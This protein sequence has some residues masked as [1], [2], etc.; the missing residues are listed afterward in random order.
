MSKIKYYNYQ[1]IGDIENNY[2]P[3]NTQLC[4]ETS[5]DVL[6]F[7]RPADLSTILKTADKGVTVSIVMSQ[8][9]NIIAMWYDRINERIYVLDKDEL[10]YLDLSDDSDNSVD[11]GLS[12][13]QGGDCFIIGTDIFVMGIYYDA[14]KGY[15]RIK[16]Y[17]SSHVWQANYDLDLGLHNIFSR[18]LSISFVVIVGTDVY[19]L[20]RWSDENCFIYK[21]DSVAN[22]YTNMEDCGANTVIPPSYNQRGITYDDSDVLSFVLQDSGD[23]KYYLHTYSITGDAITKKAEYNAT[24]MLNR[25][26]DS[27]N[28][29]PFNLEKGFDISRDA[30]DKTR[31]YQI[32]GTLLAA[33]SRVESAN[34]FAAITDTYLIDKGGALWK[35]VEFTSWMTQCKISAME[36]GAWKCEIYSKVSGKINDISSTLEIFD[37]LYFK[38]VGDLSSDSNTGLISYFGAPDNFNDEV[39]GTSGTDIDWVDYDWSV[40]A[41]AIT[42]IAEYQD[43]KNVMECKVDSGDTVDTSHVRMAETSKTYEFWMA[44]SDISKASWFYFLASGTGIGEPNT[45]AFLRFFTSKLQFGHGDGAG[46]I[47]TVDLVSPAVNNTY[48]HIKIMLDCVTDTV[49]L[50]LNGVLTIDAEEFYKDQTFDTTTTVRIHFTDAGD[51]SLYV[52]AWGETSDADYYVGKNAIKTKENVVIMEGYAKIEKIEALTKIVIDSPAMWDL[53]NKIAEGNYSGD[54][55]AIL[56][57]IAAASFQYVTAGTMSAGTAMGTIYHRGSKTGKTV[58]NTYSQFEKFTWVVKPDDGQGLLNYNDGSVDS[59]VNVSETDKISNF[60]QEVQRSVINQM[61]VKG[62]INPATGIPYTGTYNNAQSQQLYGVIPG[63]RTFAH[64]TSDAQCLAQATAMVETYENAPFKYTFTK[65]IGAE[66]LVLPSEEITFVYAPQS[67]ASAQRII[68]KITYW[69]VRGIADWEIVDALF[70]RTTQNE[71]LKE[72]VQ[73]NNDYIEQNAENISGNAKVYQAAGDPTVN[74]DV[75]LGYKRGDLW[76]NT[77]DDGAFICRNPADGAADWKEI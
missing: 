11:N 16:E 60:K 38:F 41:S 52:D 54:S 58:I 21:F 6:I 71:Q 47:T 70:Y 57:L 29:P 26:T 37:G 74:D 56:T 43:H 34:D 69:G 55:D 64:L 75:D 76:I 35:L 9:E 27:T 51:Y 22:T 61:N 19:F 1:K 12:L 31:I 2:Y 72:Q 46:G 17:N 5:N 53:K 45:L 28:D 62:M 63:Y 48:Y 20:V 49:S 23:L 7:I 24:L 65:A 73:E 33:I 66:G 59:G 40:G 39:V 50:Y 36:R 42:I 44:T 25:N 4:I 67:I 10:A 13:D 18:T 14:T 77:T 15:I 68:T 30:N 3:A 32:N 8:S